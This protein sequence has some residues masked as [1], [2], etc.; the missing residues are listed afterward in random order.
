MATKY[1]L[2]VVGGGPSG[3]EAAKTASENG[4][5]V[6]LLEMKTNPAKIQRACAQM[7]LLN[8]DRFYNERMYFS[9]EQQKWVFPMNNFSVN[10]KGSYREFYACHFIAPNTE[11]RIAAARRFYNGNVRDLN[12]L[13]ESFPT[14]IIGGLFRFAGGS[15]FELDSEAERVVPRL[16]L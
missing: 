4:L 15:F 10:Y 7:F 6:A 12:I 8:M 11:D 9:R 16:E 5:R 3:L 13:R 2:I 1:D 14:S